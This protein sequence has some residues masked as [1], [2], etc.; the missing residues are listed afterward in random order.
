ML[1]LNLAINE[2][3]EMEEIDRDLLELV[4]KFL[5]LGKY[6]YSHLFARS[7]VRD[8]HTFI[9]KAIWPRIFVR[10]RPSQCTHVRRTK[11]Q[12]CCI[13]MRLLFLFHRKG[14]SSFTTL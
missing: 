1:F 13:Q 10:V 4:C 2:F 14:H 8:I 9:H 11:V 6:L 12:A 7:F 5:K 3:G